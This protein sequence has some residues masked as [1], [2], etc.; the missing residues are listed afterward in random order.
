MLIERAI[1]V[2]TAIGFISGLLINLQEVG[3]DYLINKAW[4]GWGITLKKVAFSVS[5]LSFLFGIG[6]F[7]L[8]HW[9]PARSLGV[10]SSEIIPFF[11]KTGI[12]ISIVTPISGQI[13]TALAQ[14]ETDEDSAVTKR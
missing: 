12:L 5:S 4:M 6:A 10:T 13:R 1:L 3:L 14:R 9:E 2:A 7:L 8:F 11:F